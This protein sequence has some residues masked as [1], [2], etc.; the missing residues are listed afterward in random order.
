MPSAP[1]GS[2]ER[3]DW[4]LVAGLSL[5]MGGFVATITAP[6][7][8]LPLAVDALGVT[9]ARASLLV[10]AVFLTWVILQVPGGILLDR[11][12]NRRAI[13]L[14][15][16][17][18]LLTTLWSY[19]AP[20]FPQILLAR[21]LTGAAGV[22]IFVGGVHLLEHVV[23]EDAQALATGVFVASPPMGVALSQSTASRLAALGDWRTPILAYTG[24]IA[25]G[26]LV[27][28]A[29]LRRPVEPQGPPAT[30]QDVLRALRAPGVLLVSLAGLS[31][32]F[33]W[34]YLNTWMPTYGTEVVGVGL[35]AAGAASALVPIAGIAARPT[36]GWLAQHLPGSLTRIIAGAFL[37]VVPLV[38][39]LHI[40]PNGV[41]FA[42]LLAFAGFAVNLPV[43][44]YFLQVQELATEGTGATSLAVLAT[45]SQVGNLVAPATGGWL[46]EHVSWS[47]SF[48]AVVGAA[49]LGLGATMGA[50]WVARRT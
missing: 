28:L 36:G 35:V 13:I 14:A 20:T 4:L 44:L 33:I 23:P 7:S 17:W 16:A 25:L 26:L 11:V 6:A 1:P 46:I 38:L 49:V 45:F 3:A 5:I 21:A 39:A 32:Y 9:K 42:L 47:A 19:L 2:R 40:V 41:A 37:A 24:V 30:P 31:T 34:T 50:W 27:L 22:L 18:L 10:S 8:V 15:T 12:D 29:T 48:L 43:G